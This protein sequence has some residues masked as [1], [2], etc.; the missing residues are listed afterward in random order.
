VNQTEDYVTFGLRVARNSAK[1]RLPVSA[2]LE[3][4]HRCPF[5]CP[6][7]T[8]RLSVDD[9]H[10][11]HN[12]LNTD[13]LDRILTELAEL[14]CLWL[15]ITGGEPLCRPDFLDVYLRAKRLGFLITL[16]TNGTL[17][18]PRIADTLA[19]SP[20]MDVEISLYSNTSETCARVTGVEDTRARSLEGV[21]R[22]RDRGVSV[23]LKTLA[24]AAN[25]HEVGAL[26]RESERLGLM[27]RFDGLVTPR[28]DRSLGNLKSGCRQTRWWRW[29]APIRAAWLPSE[30]P[31]QQ[32]RRCLRVSRR[33][34]TGAGR[35][36]IPAPLIRAATC[37]CAANRARSLGICARAPFAKVGSS[38]Y[39]TSGRRPRPR[40]PVAH[41]ARYAIS[42]ACAPPTP[43]WSTTIPRSRSSFSAR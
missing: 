7:C 43:P 14:G 2:T 39:A 4:T 10:A 19:R 11:L 15:L 18:D 41:A 32:R 21:Q 9:A 30:T 17:I 34:C 22:L 26:R 37:S 24:V 29:T 33:T 27:F 31:W 6:H 20:P 42:V 38:C 35:D 36:S 40:P 23:S 13:E 16:F 25:Q 5:R 3:L 8:N 12:E 28:I 1:R